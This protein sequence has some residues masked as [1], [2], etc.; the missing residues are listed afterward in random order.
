MFGSSASYAVGPYLYPRPKLN[1][2]SLEKGGFNQM[3]ATKFGKW[4][5]NSQKYWNRSWAF[6]EPGENIDNTFDKSTY[7]A[8]QQHEYLICHEWADEAL[9]PS[10]VLYTTWRFTA[11]HKILPLGVIYTAPPPIIATL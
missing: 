7:P 4:K 5:K 3:K 2:L 1:V 9:L 10:G 8:K 6:W 11:E